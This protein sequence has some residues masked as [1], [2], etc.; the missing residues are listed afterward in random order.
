MLSLLLSSVRWHCGL[1]VSS[2]WLVSLAFLPAIG[3]S[4][5]HEPLCVYDLENSKNV[6]ATIDNSLKCWNEKSKNTCDKWWTT[7]KINLSTFEMCR[8]DDTEDEIRNSF[9]S[10]PDIHY[11][12]VHYVDVSWWRCN[13]I[14]A[15]ERIACCPMN[16]SHLTFE[17]T[18]AHT[19]LPSKRNWFSF[20]FVCYW[21]EV[22]I[23]HEFVLSSLLFL[24]LKM[25]A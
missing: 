14:M 22:I 13:S 18:R 11:E 15:D 16:T 3:V 1:V 12:E 19:K 7:K 9:C 23:K 4:D 20:E 25:I 17:Y 10:L 5:V 6:L 24:M 21:T 2:F 8:N